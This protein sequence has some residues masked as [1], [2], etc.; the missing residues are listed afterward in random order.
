MTLSDLS[1]LI[2]EI[3][4]LSAES[5][6]KLADYITF[7]KW[8]EQQRQPGKRQSWS[9]SFIETFK[10]ASVFATDKPAGMDV[11]LAPATVGG[12]KRPALW[13]HPPVVGQ[14]V[15]EYYV[16]VPQQV[17]D[18]RLHLAIGIRDGAKISEDNLVAFGLKI[19]GSRVWGEQSN[20]LTWQEANIALDV[21]A[22]DMIRFEFTT[23]ALNS[24]EW[25]WAVWGNPELSGKID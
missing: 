24:H 15:I 20:S 1:K 22:G 9:Y 21:A 10:T 17:K 11:Q 18:I 25:T 19:N 14:A 5:R 16:P 3:E 6:A 12:Q 2:T 13:A 23:E 4:G 8:Q 7:L